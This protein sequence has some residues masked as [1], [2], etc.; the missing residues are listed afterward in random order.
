[1]SCLTILQVESMSTAA[2]AKA[3]ILVRTTLSELATPTA[4]NLSL[5]AR[6]ALQAKLA[7]YPQSNKPTG[8]ASE[9][10]SGVKSQTQ[11]STKCVVISP[12]V[13]GT[14]PPSSTL[15]PADLTSPSSA[16]VAAALGDTGKPKLNGTEGGVKSDQKKAEESSESSTTSSESSSS[17]ESDGEKKK[18]AAEVINTPPPAKRKRGRPP[19]SAQSSIAG[20]TVHST[21]RTPK[22]PKSTPRRRP[23]PPLVSVTPD[24]KTSRQR[25]RGCGN[26]PG[27]LRDD[28]GKCPYCLDK[29][30]F[31]GPGVKKQRCSLRVCS[32]FVSL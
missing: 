14:V 16:P 11:S 2:P 29:P 31:G 28:C 8:Q 15:T 12:L 26:C 19:K 23:P 30:K 10:G 22:T 24:V 27:C 13:P 32:N 3:E 25:G 18:K 5:Q 17:S 1:M 6:S 20:P 9:A 7:E 4:E 21:G